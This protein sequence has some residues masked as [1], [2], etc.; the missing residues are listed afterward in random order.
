M[1]TS[2]L[3]RGKEVWAGTEGVSGDLPCLR[4]QLLSWAPWSLQ[5]D[6][7]FPPSQEHWPICRKGTALPSCGIWKGWE[8]GQKHPD[9]QVPGSKECA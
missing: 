8:C 7:P 1:T 6:L 9:E 3:S 5:A 4:V 2:Q